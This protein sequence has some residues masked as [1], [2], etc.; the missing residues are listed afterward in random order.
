ME[1]DFIFHPIDVNSTKCQ[2]LS[3]LYEIKMS[4][5][6]INVTEKEEKTMVTPSPLSL[7]INI[8]MFNKDL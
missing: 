8:E 6:M 1:N 3:Q 5:I 4:E 2:L 7:K